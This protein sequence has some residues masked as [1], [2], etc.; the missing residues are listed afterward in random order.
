MVHT[1]PQYYSYSLQTCKL[2]RSLTSVCFAERRL[3]DQQAMHLLDVKFLTLLCC[4]VWLYGG[5]YGYNLADDTAIQLRGQKS[6]RNVFNPQPK[7]FLHP[8]LTTAAAC[9]VAAPA[10]VVAAAAS[11]AAVS[12][13]VPFPPVKSRRPL[14]LRSVEQP[15]LQN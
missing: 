7:P 3:L 14:V 4:C 15:A 6:N 11:A 13:R 12:F 9:L 8:L 2:C 5:G 10:A 1:C